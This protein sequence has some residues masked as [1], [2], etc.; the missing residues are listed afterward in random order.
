MKFLELGAFVRKCLITVLVIQMRM[1]SVFCQNVLRTANILTH[2][3][4][5]SEGQNEKVYVG[6][7]DARVLHLSR[8]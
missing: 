6:L 2:S 7:Q 4:R 5:N 3:V 8:S 1:A